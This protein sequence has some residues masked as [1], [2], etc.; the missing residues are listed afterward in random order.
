MRNRYVV[1]RQ[2]KLVA[3]ILYSSNNTHYT[4]AVILRQNIGLDGG[5]GKWGTKQMSF[6]QVY[7]LFN[8]VHTQQFAG[9][10]TVRTAKA[11][12]EFQIAL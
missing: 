5:Q 3:S 6:L 10:S 7:P 8:D 2:G 1:D 12:V 11:V 4:A 9:W